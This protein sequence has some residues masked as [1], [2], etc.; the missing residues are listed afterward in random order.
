VTTEWPEG[1]P[2][3]RFELTFEEV[4][5]GTKV[6]MVHSDVP[7]EQ[8]KALKEGWNKF[9]WRPLKDYFKKLLKQK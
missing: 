7:A 9:Y 8:A 3:S 6:S 2:P 4:E 5:G 1:Y